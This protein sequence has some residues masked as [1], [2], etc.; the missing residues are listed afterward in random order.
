MSER[1]GWHWNLRIVI[2]AKFSTIHTHIAEFV[3]TKFMLFS[4]KVLFMQIWTLLVC[5]NIIISYCQSKKKYKLPHGTLL[6]VTGLCAANSPL[7][8]ELPAQRASNA[9]N[10]SI[11]WHYQTKKNRSR[12]IMASTPLTVKWQHFRYERPVWTQS[13]T[14]WPGDVR[15]FVTSWVVLVPNIKQIWVKLALNHGADPTCDRRKGRW[16]DEQIRRL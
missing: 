11:W 6:C 16:R 9:G 12:E 2:V 3:R 14:F 13:L 1:A 5:L 7:T 4:W 15:N 8:G 10:V